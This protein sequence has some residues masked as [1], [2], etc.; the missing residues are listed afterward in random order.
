MVVNKKTKDEQ[1]ESFRN[2][3]IREYCRLFLLENPKDRK[4]RKVQLKAQLKRL[5]HKNIVVNLNI[6]LFF[7]P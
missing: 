3:L 4:R 2:K 6:L 1:S 7:S 5:K